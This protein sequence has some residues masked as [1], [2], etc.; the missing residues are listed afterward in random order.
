MVKFFADEVKGLKADI[1]RHTEKEIYLKGKI[2]EMEESGNARGVR[3]YTHVL[4]LLL[5]SKAELTS[6]IGRK[7]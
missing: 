1:K 3:V 6:K 2:E 5:Q 7:K 4:E